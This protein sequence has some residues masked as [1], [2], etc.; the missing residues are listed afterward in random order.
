MAQVKK[1]VEDLFMPWVMTAP[2]YS[3]AVCDVAWEHPELGRMMLNENPVPPSQKVVEA[4][5]GI[6]KQGN[7]YPDRMLR[8][9]AKLGE[10]HGVGPENIAVA[11]GS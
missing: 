9:R 6:I 10:L 7:R 8:L 4:A 2:Q 3:I 11:N 1:P 5:A